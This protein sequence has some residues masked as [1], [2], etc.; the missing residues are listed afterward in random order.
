MVSDLIQS[1]S[2]PIGVFG[3]GTVG[4]QIGTTFGDRVAA[5]IDNKKTGE[6]YGK[7]ILSLDVFLEMYP[8]SFIIVANKFHYDEIMEQIKA[9]GIVED[10][11]FNVGKL[12][13]E[14]CHKQY[15]DLPELKNMRRKNEVFAD[16]GDLMEVQQ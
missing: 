3:A 2:K 4:K 6:F 11:L 7:P 5:F 1:I 14:L 16:G 12:Y 13:E 8:D 10:K 9:K 15:F